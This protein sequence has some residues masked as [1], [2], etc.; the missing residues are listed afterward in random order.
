MQNVRRQNFLSRK[1][2]NIKEEEAYNRIN[3]TNVSDL[4]NRGR[5]LYKFDVNVRTK[6]VTYKW[7]SGRG[8]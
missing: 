6:S 8:V 7:K 2:L 3:Y 1:G 4:R 5:Y